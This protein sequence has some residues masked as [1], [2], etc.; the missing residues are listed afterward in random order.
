MRRHFASHLCGFLLAIL[1]P[2]VIGYA[3]VGDLKT[4]EV[5]VKLRTGGELS[6]ALLDSNGH[7]LVILSKNVPYVFGWRELDANSAFH[8]KRSLLTTERD[9]AERLTADDHFQLGLLALELGRNDLASG[10]FDLARK[11]D[12]TLAPQIKNAFAKFRREADVWK[13]EKTQ[14][15]ASQELAGTG[16]EKRSNSLLA[17][18]QLP[19]ATEQVRGDVRAAYLKF[20]EKVREVLGRDIQ[21]IESDHFLI[22]SDWGP[23]ERANLVQ[24]SESMYAALCRRFGL[25]PLDDIFLAKCPLF[26]FRSKAR[27]SR[28]ARDFDGYDAKN[29]IGYTRSIEANGHVH[30]AFAR[31]GSTPFDYD[32]FACTLVHE[33]THAFLHRVY[34]RHLLPPWLNEG[35]AELTAERI[36]GDRCPAGENAELLARQYARFDWSALPLL[37]RTSAIEV[38]EYPLAHSIVAY[39]DT[40]S[41]KG[42]ADLVRDLKQGQDLAN[43]L[44]AEYEGLTIQEL[45]KDWKR[46][47]AAALPEFSKN[48]GATG[49]GLADQKSGGMP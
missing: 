49:G 32:R 18:E 40:R 41:T 42:L 34:G 13:A 8:V 22:W 12:D 26:C 1:I 29:A 10:E 11:L 20:G 47:I 19:P 23:K 3:G 33:G 25:D 45:E 6:G 16:E 24:W 31:M 38:H 48:G 15:I 5:A 37:E 30:M 2:G 17:L 36:L 14:P 27:F 21:L 35:L 28:F 4:I 46:S 43:A 39:L 9:G 7:G 44:A